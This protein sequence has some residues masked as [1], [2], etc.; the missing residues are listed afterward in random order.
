MSLSRQE[1]L[2]VL[3]LRNRHDTSPENL[4]KDV[5]VFLEFLEKY[6]AASKP[7]EPKGGNSHGKGKSGNANNP[8]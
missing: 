4:L 6:P 8:R 3:E 1:V 2:K 5:K 7:E